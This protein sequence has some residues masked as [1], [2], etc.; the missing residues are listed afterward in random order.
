VI[1]SSGCDGS[2]R[3]SSGVGAGSTGRGC[4]GLVGTRGV[5]WSAGDGEGEAPKVF[6]RSYTGCGSRLRAA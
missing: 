2:P 5:W 3:V 4:A 1:V 6:G